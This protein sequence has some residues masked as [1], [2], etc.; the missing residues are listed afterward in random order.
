MAENSISRKYT[1]NIIPCRLEDGKYVPD[2]EVTTIKDPITIR[3]STKKIM[4]NGLDCTAKIEIY[5]LNKTTRD[6]IFYDFLRMENFRI[7]ELFAGYEGKVQSLIFKGIIKYCRPKKTN[8]DVIMDIEAFSGLYVLNNNE[9]TTLEGEMSI[10]Q[11]YTKLANDCPG[12]TRGTTE[13]EEKFLPRTV[14]L[15]GNS[16]Q[17][18]KT[19]TNDKVSLNDEELIVMDANQVIEGDVKVIDDE[20]GLL[21]IPERDRTTLTVNCMFEP[22]I[23]L[24]QV[25]EIRSKIAPMFD[26]QYKV[27]GISHDGIISGSI[28]GSLVTKITLYTGVNLFGHFESTWEKV[29]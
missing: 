4:Y 18:L 25:L 14:S 16:V 27:W 26:G 15:M 29:L 10:E 11:I 6:N 20:T 23:Q 2:G 13:L 28:S 1:L 21:G 5:N 17:L 22:R 3:F 12:V 24:G 9:S 8:T 7:I 19:Y